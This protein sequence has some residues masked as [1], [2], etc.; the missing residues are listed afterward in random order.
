MAGKLPTKQKEVSRENVPEQVKTRSM[1][2]KEIAGRLN[3]S[4]RQAKRLYRAYRDKVD[5]GLIHGKS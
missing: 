2:L 4:Y 3:I 5:A 1:T